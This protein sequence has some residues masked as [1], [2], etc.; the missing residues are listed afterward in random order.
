MVMIYH[1]IMEKE[2][3]LLMCWKLQLSFWLLML[4]FIQWNFSWHIIMRMKAPKEGPC[5]PIGPL[6]LP[7]SLH[8][9][10]RISQTNKLSVVCFC[11]LFFGSLFDISFF[12]FFHF[13][14]FDCSNWCVCVLHRNSCMVMLLQYLWVFFFFKLFLTSLIFGDDENVQW[15]N[16]EGIFLLLLSHHIPWSSSGQFVWFLLFQNSWSNI[17]L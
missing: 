13:I 15:A 4:Q 5:D 9:F 16:L 1:V 17:N 6:E 3:Q 11:F 14:R 7:H 10:H 12:C 2:I 8:V